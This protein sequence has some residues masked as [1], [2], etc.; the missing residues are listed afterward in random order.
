[1]KCWTEGLARGGISI[2]PGCVL[3]RLE[4]HTIQG[5][6]CGGELT[7]WKLRLGD[8]HRSAMPR[9]GTTVT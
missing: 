1:L 9:R 7:S 8:V 4:M 5:A 2:A 3:L 6:P